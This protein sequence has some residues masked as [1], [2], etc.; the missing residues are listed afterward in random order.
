MKLSSMNPTRLTTWLVPGWQ[1]FVR[2]RYL[3]GSF[4]L[5][6]AVIGYWQGILPGVAIH[7][8]Y[9]LQSLRSPNRDRNS[10]VTSTDLSATPAEF[11]Q[12]TIALTR[13]LFIQLR[14]RPSTL[15]VGIIQPLMWLVLFGALFRQTSAPLFGGEAQYV[16]FLTSGLIVFAALNGALYAGLAVMFDREFGFLNRLLVAPLASRFSIVLASTLFIMLQTLLQTAIILSV[17]AVLGAGLPGPLQF[18]LMAL[19]IF[20]L[21]LGVTGFS[22]GLAFT[23]PGHIELLGV[24]FVIELPMLFVSTVLAPMSGMSTWLAYLASINPLSYATEAIRY[25]YMQAEFS[26]GAQ[27][28]AAPWGNVS[29]LGA[30]L[31]LV[32]FDVLVLLSIRPLLHRRLAE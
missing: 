27:A 7:G 26:L 24:I 8:I 28:I 4:W 17:G 25:L 10:S 19:T 6:G 9:L 29:F 22:L 32:G 31:I 30:L 16:R 23:L 14:R 12:E 2:H 5:I 18:V 21:T 11:F 3:L 15:V 13:R 20:L 1:Q